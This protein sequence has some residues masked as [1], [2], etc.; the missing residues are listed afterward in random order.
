[1]YLVIDNVWSF[2]WA[3]LVIGNRSTSLLNTGCGIGSE[4]LLLVTALLQAL[5]VPTF[6]LVLLSLLS[7]IE[8]VVGQVF[9]FVN[10]VE[11]LSV[12]LILDAMFGGSADHLKKV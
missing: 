8:I 11:A 10:L 3:S 5:I 2:I 1:M 12:G 9:V 6:R 4:V 7:L